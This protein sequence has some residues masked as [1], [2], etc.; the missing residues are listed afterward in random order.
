M[1]FIKF[2]LGSDND[3]SHLQ[4]GESIS[5]YKSAMWIERYRE[6]GEFTFEGKLSS[7]LK[8][9]VPVGTLITHKDTYE[10]ATVENHEI[11]ETIDSD[12]TI[13]ITGRGL[14]TWLENRIV[15]MNQNWAAPPAVLPEYSLPADYTHNQAVK[16]INDHIR[17]ST[18]IDDDNALLNIMAE[19]NVFTTGESVLRVVKRGPVFQALLELLAVDDLGI[20]VI[21]ANDFGVMGNNIFTSFM[22]HKGIDRSANVIFSWT[23]GDLDGAGYLFTNKALKNA[24]LVTGRY[25]ETAVVPPSTIKGLDRRWMLVDGSDIDGSLSAPPTGGALTTVRAKMVTRGQQALQDQNIVHIVRSD[26]SPLTKFHYRKDYDV[27][28]IVAVD[29]SYGEV[30][31]RRIIEYVEIEDENGESGH[32]TVSAL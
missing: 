7:G 25:V 10:V 9:A 32:P 19:T 30:E 23:S 20:R 1:D 24:A 22:I 29:G 16:L 4:L 15:G 3:R 2:N 12:P 18:L 21:R 13:K 26:I 31:E 14:E 5:G 28:D 27:G 11:I 17:A 8:E 6:P